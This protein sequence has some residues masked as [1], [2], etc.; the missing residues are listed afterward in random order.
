MKITYDTDLDAISS[1]DLTADQTAQL[2]RELVA[3]LGRNDPVRT[4]A[5][6]LMQL[7]ASLATRS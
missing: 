4:V 1:P 7:G 6:N 3:A 5:A 2:Q